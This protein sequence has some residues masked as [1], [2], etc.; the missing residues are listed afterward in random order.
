MGWYREYLD[1]KV[2][3]WQETGEK[4]TEEF[5]N[6]Y[7]LPNTEVEM[8]RDCSMHGDEKYVENFG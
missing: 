8:G 4:C 7:A 5:H 1:P 3:P 2:A 6:L